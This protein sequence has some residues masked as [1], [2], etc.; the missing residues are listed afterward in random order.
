MSRP[1]RVGATVTITVEGANDAIAGGLVGWNER[2]DSVELLAGGG[3]G[4]G[5]RRH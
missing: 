2:R 3:D 4:H 1:L 5:G